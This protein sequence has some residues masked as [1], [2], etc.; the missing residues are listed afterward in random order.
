MR[1]NVSAEQLRAAV[2]PLTV[3]QY[4]G[5]AQSKSARLQRRYRLRRVFSVLQ[6]LP[7]CFRIVAG[8][9]VLS[10]SAWNSAHLKLQRCALLGWPIAEFRQ[11]LLLESFVVAASGSVVGSLAAFL[12]SQAILSALKTWWVDAVGTRD[13]NVVFSPV[14]L[15]IGIAAGLSWRLLVIWG[16]LRRL[17]KQ[18]PRET[19]IASFSRND[20]RDRSQ[21]WRCGTARRWAAREDSSEQAH[22]F[23]PPLFC[24]FSAG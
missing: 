1:T 4:R 12:Y 6:F 20:L 9:N 3:L 5:C 16:T 13:L 18:A 7:R 19:A 2:D 17:G 21:F 24:L 22:C 23:L 15:T 11:L 14:A 10:L 8:R